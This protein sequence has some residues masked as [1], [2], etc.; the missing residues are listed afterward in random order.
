MANHNPKALPIPRTPRPTV[1]PR[2]AADRA[3]FEAASY[4]RKAPATRTTKAVA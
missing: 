3:A 1:P 4:V 2:S